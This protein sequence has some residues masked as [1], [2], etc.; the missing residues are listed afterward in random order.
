MKREQEG[1]NNKPGKTKK[2]RFQPLDSHWDERESLAPLGGE[3][4]DTTVLKMPDMLPLEDSGTYIEG[5]VTILAPPT[6]HQEP[7]N[8]PTPMEPSTLANWYLKVP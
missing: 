2:L 4:E 6:D 7:N 8:T 3:I 5:W 1:N